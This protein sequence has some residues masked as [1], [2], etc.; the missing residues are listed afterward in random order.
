MTLLR[1]RAALE[2]WLA[3]VDELLVVRRSDA[4]DRED[5]EDDEK[6]GLMTSGA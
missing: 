6:K 2:S 4:E 1:R 3:H 5:R